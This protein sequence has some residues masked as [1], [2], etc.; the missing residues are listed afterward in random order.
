MHT[1]FDHK[2][3]HHNIDIVLALFIQHDLFI[4][5]S[6]H[7]VD[8]N[9]YKALRSQL[10]QFVLVFAFTVLNNRCQDLQL[11]SRWVLHEV[12]HHLIHSLRAHRRTAL[13]AMLHPDPSIKNTQIVVN[14]GNSTHC[15]TWILAAGFLFDGYSRRQ[16]FNEIH[17]GLV[18]L[19]QKLPGICGE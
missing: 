12:F 19:S 6:Q 8:H 15:G 3:I 4:Q 13:I 1:I 10:F 14:L 7:I 9:S 11:A 16:S 2:A 5:I 18:H 17:L